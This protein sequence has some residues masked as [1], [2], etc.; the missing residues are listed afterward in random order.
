MKTIYVLAMVLTGIMLKPAPQNPNDA[1]H[2][3]VPAGMLILA[4]RID[5]VPSPVLPPCN[6]ATADIFQCQAD[7]AKIRNDAEER[8]SLALEAF[9]YRDPKFFK[10]IMDFYAI[11]LRD[12]AK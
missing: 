4:G 8:M 11:S 1:P 7:A 2:T 5:F 3:A 12:R 9:R 6:P 10:G